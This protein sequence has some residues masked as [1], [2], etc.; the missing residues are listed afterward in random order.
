[1]HWDTNGYTHTVR[2]VEILRLNYIVT[3]HMSIV[4]EMQFASQY[5]SSDINEDYIFGTHV[6]YK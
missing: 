2:T 5:R 3:S 6:I 4:I 1:M